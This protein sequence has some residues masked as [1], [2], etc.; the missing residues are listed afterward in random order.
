MQKVQSVEEFENL[1]EQ[2]GR[3]F[4]FKHSLTCPISGNAYNQYQ[5]FTSGIDEPSYY[6]AVQEARALSN[7][8]AERFGIRHESPQAFLFE[9]GEPIWNASHNRITKEALMKL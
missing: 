3:F 4:F 2:E 7:Y 6:L 5:T 8:I 9:K 1:L